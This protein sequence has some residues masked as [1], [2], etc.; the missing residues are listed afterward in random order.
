MTQGDPGY[1]FW[2]GCTITQR[3]LN[4]SHLPLP[5]GV[6]I[7]AQL[8]M[9]LGTFSSLIEGLK[10]PLGTE[11]CPNH[12]V[13]IPWELLHTA[14]CP[15]YLV[16]KWS[17]VSLTDTVALKGALQEGTMTRGRVSPLECQAHL[18]PFQVV[19]KLFQTLVHGRQRLKGPA[20]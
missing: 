17:V 8:P 6:C 18:N 9:G 19:W 13:G 2:A 11:V 20:L 5:S 1:R 10:H 4:I 12:P 14:A 15:H 7:Q 3:G 16:T